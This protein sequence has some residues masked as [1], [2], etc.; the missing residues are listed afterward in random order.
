MAGSQAQ[1]KETRPSRYAREALSEW[2]KAARYSSRAVSPAL[3][4]VASSLRP[5]VKPGGGPGQ[6]LRERLNPANTEK[7]GRLGDAADFALEKLGGPAGKAISRFAGGSRIV[8]RLRSGEEDAGDESAG[9]GGESGERSGANGSSA[10]GFHGRL[11]VPIQESIEVAVPVQAAYRL[12]TRFDEYPRFLDRVETAERITK[13]RVYVAASIRGRRREL[14][15]QIV[16]ERPNERLDW[17]CGDEIE[18]SGVVSFHEL[19]PRL[20]HIELTVE[21][22]PSGVVERL[23]RTAGLTERAIRA[24]LHRFKAYA[25]LFEDDEVEPAGEEEPDAEESA[26]DADEEEGLEDEDESEAQYV[27]GEEYEDGDELE[28]EEDDDFEGQ[29]DEEYEDE[30][31]LEEDDFEGQDDEEYEDEEDLEEDEELEPARARR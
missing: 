22:E 21:L 15:A 20:T 2:A 17:E 1:S 5:R 3:K 28:D 31:D 13:G 7:G 4:E 29:D 19:A 24:D 30:E 16:D 9:R 11:P 23:T 12:F 18:H 25:E 27:D 8:E 26:A 6:S 10:N 14:I